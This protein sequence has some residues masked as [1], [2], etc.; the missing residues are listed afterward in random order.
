MVDRRPVDTPKI[1]EAALSFLV[2]HA[3][4]KHSKRGGSFETCAGGAKARSIWGEKRVPKSANLPPANGC[5]HNFVLEDARRALRQE[6]AIPSPKSMG[7]A[8][9]T[10]EEREQRQAEEL[11][12]AEKVRWPMPYSRLDLLGACDMRGVLHTLMRRFAHHC[13]CPSGS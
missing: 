1:N 2:G 11:R 8:D 3:R 7:L 10:A 12:N 6:L 5:A 13:S 9:E 4:C